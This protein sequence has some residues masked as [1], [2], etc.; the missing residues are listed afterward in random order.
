MTRQRAGKGV[1]TSR[2]TRERAQANLPTL[3]VALVVL[4][5]VTGLAFAV[6]DAAF[7]GTDRSAD[8]RRI[9]LS[10][11]DRLVAA[12]TLLTE[13]ANVLNASAVAAT[14][15]T[16][17]ERAFP[18]VGGT[19]YTVSLDG[20]PVVTNGTTDDGTTV[21]RIVLVANRSTQRIE[22]AFSASN[23]VTLP[24]RVD[25]ARLT[26]SPSSNVTIRTVRAN[27]RVLLRDTGGL[28]GNYTV[29]LSGRETTTLRFDASD[30][31]ESGAVIVRIRPA[32]T[33][34]ARLGVTV[35]A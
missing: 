9:A 27:G 24:R 30:R 22:P 17:F 3:A 15:A 21:R 5:A 19:E 25:S 2:R 23:A 26:L 16:A 7:A 1:R 34:K 12:D 14:D 20:E 18:V 28:A 31:L 32:R 11:S 8:E 13:R 33:H 6:T 29:S 35:D 4:T 10:L